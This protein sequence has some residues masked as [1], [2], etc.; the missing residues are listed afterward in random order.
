LESTLKIQDFGRHPIEEMDSR[1]HC[2]SPILIR[3][4]SAKQKSPSS[5]QD[6]MVLSLGY[7]V[8]LRGLWAGFFMNKTVVLEVS[9]KVSIYKF[10][11]IA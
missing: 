3:N 11:S 6:M 2:I 5:F 4:I 1:G 9:S 10:P 7:L 8:L